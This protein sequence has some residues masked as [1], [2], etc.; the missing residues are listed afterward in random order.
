MNDKKKIAVLLPNKEDYSLN[1]AAAASIWV[2]DYN[3]G[4]IINKQLIFG[5]ASSSP[6]SK[7]FINLRIE[8]IINNS[9]F[10]LRNFIKKLPNSIKVIEIHNRPHFFFFLKKISII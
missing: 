10:Y 8:N 6:L 4:K 5:I 7:N 3:E 1:K 2:N 9:F